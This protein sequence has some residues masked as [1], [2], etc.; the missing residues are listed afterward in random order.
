MQIVFITTT[1]YIDIYVFSSDTHILLNINAWI[2]I[3]ILLLLLNS[4]LSRKMRKKILKKCQSQNHR[5]T[6]ITMY[7]TSL[8]IIVVG[9]SFFVQNNW[10]WA[11]NIDLLKVYCFIYTPKKMESQYIYIYIVRIL[12]IHYVDYRL[13][14]QLHFLVR[15]ILQVFTQFAFLLLPLLHYL[16]HIWCIVLLDRFILYKITY[17]YVDKYVG[18][19]WL[20]PF[21]SLLLLIPIIITNTP[22]DKQTYYSTQKQ[23]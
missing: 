1:V 14:C 16:I 19:I 7:T 3:I 2:I 9:S 20:L 5:I 15:H 4:I 23:Y 21:N 6:Q 8:F 22:A 12:W 10:K 13:F 17:A 11:R 18:Q